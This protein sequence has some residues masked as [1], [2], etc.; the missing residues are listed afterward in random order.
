MRRYLL[1]TIGLLAGLALSAQDRSSATF[2][3]DPSD[4]AA[5][6]AIRARMDSIR[7]HRPTVALVL[8]GGGAKGAAHIGALRY[9]ERY[10]IP[11]DM[12]VGT[13]IGGL[14]GGCYALG[15]SP[16][17][18]DSLIR[19]ID[20]PVAMSDDVPKEY[21]P[22]SK[23]RYR[24]KF[25]LSIPFYY[26]KPDFQDHISGDIQFAGGGDGHLHLS[27][28]K[29]GASK[30]IRQ[31]LM[32]VLPSG[33]IYGQ[34]VE[35]IISSLTAGYADSTDFFQFPIPFACIAT[36][37]VSGKA[38]VWHSG[39]INTALRSTMSI[40][41]LF[42]PVRTRGMVLVDG[43]MR[44]NFPVDVARDMG[45]DIVIGIDLSD[46]KLGY[47]EIQNLADIVW[48]GIDMFGGDSFERNV[49]MVD[50]RIKPELSGYNMMSFSAES[51]DS[52]LVRGYEAAE[53]KDEEL[54][55]IRRWLGKDTLRLSGKPAV[56]VNGHPV[57]IDDIEIAGVSEREREYILSAIR[58]QPGRLVDRRGIEQAIATIYGK[59]AYDYVNY[60]LLG[61]GDSYR[62]RINCKKGPKHQLGVGFRVDTEELVSILLNVGL[63]TNS[64]R[65]SSLDMTA[66]VGANPYFNAHYA[67]NMQKAPTLNA[68]AGIRWT[69]RNN[70]ISGRNRYNISYL[71][72]SQELF[73][74]NMHW[75]QFDV[76]GGVRNDYFKVHRL[77]SSDVVGDYARNLEAMDYPALF[78]DATTDNLDDG[79]F[80]KEGFSAK[81]RYEL[82]SRMSDGPDYPG[83]F[84]ILALGGR[85]AVPVGSRFTLIPQGDMRLVFGDDIP[86]P[87]ANVLG[88]DM[89]GRYVDHQIPFIG[90]DNA[91]F[92][93]NCL[94]DT[95][96]DLR[97]EVARNNYLTGTFNYA[98]DFYNFSQYELGEDVFGCGLGYAYDS[99]VG[100]LKGQVYWS[101]LTHHVGVYLSL[102]FD[103]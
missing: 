17:Y 49:A 98:R 71:M 40:P 67:Y 23:V 24:E 74:S 90:I 48:R 52:M 46:A 39:S 9:M 37:I 19:S 54:S 84:G 59:G 45:A 61:T 75:S 33:F 82:I 79:Y 15:Y 34:N 83:F 29:D 28:D 56:D 66:K 11:V 38:K 92:R 81:L 60:E 55:A 51:I 87:Y 25:A 80:P 50:L 78:I 57:Y 36:D 99:I 73:V 18:L 21:I 97:F 62:L 53:A 32:G 96:M 12:V 89:R 26:S 27:A 2:G 85:V 95:R 31:N 77:L 10:K 63:N 14:L 42:A 65:G 91:A 88:G 44:N 16:A 101:S 13:S 68:R 70:F 86:I 102:G 58:V 76:R 20:W 94:I 1:I 64:L 3:L 7:R 41:G 8:S 22:Y 43:G 30:M 35:Y 69:D 47:G 100:P 5:V 6:K 93:R 103:F 4:E 72:T